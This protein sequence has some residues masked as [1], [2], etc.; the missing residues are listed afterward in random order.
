MSE[1]I[2]SPKRGAKKADAQPESSSG[3]SEPQ[4]KKKTP[5]QW[6]QL[7]GLVRLGSPDAVVGRARRAWQYAAAAVRY[8]W[9]AHAYHFANE[10]F[11]LTAEDFDA[12]LTAVDSNVPRHEPAVSPHH[13]SR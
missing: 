7:K 5:E 3:S 12:A 6:A 11:L 1:D 9:D 4:S 10:P 2:P 13:R 8:G